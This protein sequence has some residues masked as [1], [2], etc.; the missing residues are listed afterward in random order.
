[1]TQCA[2]ENMTNKTILG[3]DPGLQYTGWG[4]IEQS[5][6]SLKFVACGTIH[7]NPKDTLPDRLLSISNGLRQVVKQYKPDECAIEET[8]MNTNPMSSLKLGHARGA[9]MLTLSLCGLQPHEYAATLVKKS[10]VGVGRAEK[11]QIGMMVK[12]LLPKAETHGEDE[13]DALAV[14][15][16]HTQHAVM[17]ELVD[18]YV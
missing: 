13:A 17:K 18:N 2:E 15:I 16:C 11:S 1:M 10:I 3:I 14:A 9:A 5:G 12:V 7:S 6:N 8:F 4:V